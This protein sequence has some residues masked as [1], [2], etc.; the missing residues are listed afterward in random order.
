MKLEQINPK[1]KSLLSFPF[2]PP[3]LGNGCIAPRSF[4]AQTLI[5]SNMIV[6]EKCP[7]QKQNH[8]SPRPNKPQITLSLL[9]RK[10]RGAAFEIAEIL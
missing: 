6:G 10:I 2:N 7:R 4:F 9:T 5:D 3:G 8:Q 1:H